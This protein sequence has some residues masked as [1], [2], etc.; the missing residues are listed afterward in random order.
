MI[1]YNISL[2]WQKTNVLTS[3]VNHHTIRAQNFTLSESEF[4][5]QHSFRSNHVHRAE[6]YTFISSSGEMDHNK[7][8]KMNRW[9]KGFFFSLFMTKKGDS[10]SSNKFSS[11]CLTW[12]ETSSEFLFT[13]SSLNTLMSN[14]IHYALDSL[15]L[16]S[17]SDND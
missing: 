14:D 11:P 9:K 6:F 8:S 1:F 12:S 4:Y 15:F 17:P 13:A 16:L 3:L 2:I 10:K 7:I 5:K